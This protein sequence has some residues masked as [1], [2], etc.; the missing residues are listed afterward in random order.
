MALAEREREN[1]ETM[2]DDAAA[3]HMYISR[4][5]MCV[6]LNVYTSYNMD[7]LICHCLDVSQTR[8]QTRRHIPPDDVAQ[9]RPH[10]NL[11]ARRRF[12]QLG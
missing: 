5:N 11:P 8:R 10:P 4:R 7:N 12:S 1:L 9:R 3:A 2:D 6:C